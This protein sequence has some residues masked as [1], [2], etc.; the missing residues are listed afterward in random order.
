MKVYPITYSVQY[1]TCDTLVA[2]FGTAG[3]AINYLKEHP[4]AMQGDEM[5]IYEIQMGEDYGY[6]DRI[7]TVFYR[8]DDNEWFIEHRGG[9]QE[10]LG[11]V[12]YN[13]ETGEDEWDR[14]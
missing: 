7:A 8:W 3:D 2:V 10:T 13:H 9:L 6:E 11:K 14:G 1:E 4:E 5:C 12:V